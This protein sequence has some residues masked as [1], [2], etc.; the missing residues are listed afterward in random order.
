[1]TWCEDNGVDYIFGWEGMRRQSGIR[2]SML[3]ASTFDPARDHVA[4]A[5][6]GFPCLQQVSFEPTQAG[7]VTNAARAGRSMSDTSRGNGYHLQWT[8]SRLTK[9]ILFEINQLTLR[10]SWADQ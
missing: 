3:Q 7:L 9:T 5:Q 8:L 6:L 10:A 2:H 1:M 4:S